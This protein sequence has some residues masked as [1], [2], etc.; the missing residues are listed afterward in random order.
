MADLELP[1]HPLVV[2]LGAALTTGSDDPMARL[3][4]ATQAGLQAQAMA[5]RAA[6]RAEEAGTDA[7]KEFEDLASAAEAAAEDAKEAAAGAE[8][9]AAKAAADKAAA[10]K[11]F[12]D[13]KEEA[14]KAVKQ[15]A[16]DATI[17]ELA[18]FGGYVGGTT[19][20]PPSTETWQ[21]LYLD[22]KLLTWLLVPRNQILFHQRMDDDKAAFNQRDFIW[23]KA[24]VPL[25]R[26]SGPPSIWLSGDFTRAVDFTPPLAGG[27]PAAPQT[28]IFCEASTPGCCPPRTR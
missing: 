19:N 5:D 6:K 16:G 3:Q 23:V 2:A 17:P 12:D 28:G 9:N 21:I 7:A 25:A 4:A 18:A 24:D 26:S 20:A 10:D 11:A 22:A 14:T 13:A 15:L 8:A 27:A 1:P